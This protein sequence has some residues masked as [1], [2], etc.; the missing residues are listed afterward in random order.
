MVSFFLHMGHFYAHGVNFFAHYCIRDNNYINNLYKEIKRDEEHGRSRETLLLYHFS[1]FHFQF[2]YKEGAN[3]D[4]P[5]IECW[6]E[7]AGKPK[8]KDKAAGKWGDYKCD[9]NPA[10]F[11][12]IKEAINKIGEPDLIVWTGDTNNHDIYFSADESL[13]STF[14]ISKELE[15]MF[16][17]SAI[18]P[19]HGNHEFAPMNSHDFSAEDV[20]IIGLISNWKLNI[21]NI[22][23]IICS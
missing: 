19:I 4:W 23:W 20:D 5:D 13:N 6:N 3:N 17:R 15:K 9:S 18:F 1:D 2:D 7:K 12:L 22:L 14:I 16:P 10:T 8:S 11:G 21:S